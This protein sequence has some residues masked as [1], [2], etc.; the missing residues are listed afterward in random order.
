ML[1]RLGKRSNIKMLLEVNSFIFFKA[2]PS[3]LLGPEWMAV[4][5]ISHLD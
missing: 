1:N 3:F 4:A 2:H 5:F